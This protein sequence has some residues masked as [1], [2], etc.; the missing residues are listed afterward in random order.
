MSKRARHGVAV[1]VALTGIVLGVIAVRK[2]V[3]VGTLVSVLTHDQMAGPAVVK[4][5]ANDL[6]ATV[7][8]PHL[9]YE[10]AGDKNVLWCATFR[11]A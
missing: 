3:G 1:L 11:I 4:A 5:D 8:T 6:Q 10:I 2:G 9:E 7:V